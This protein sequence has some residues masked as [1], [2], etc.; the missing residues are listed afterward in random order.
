MNYDWF[1]GIDISKATIDVSFCNSVYPEKYTH[2]K[3]DNTLSGFEKMVVWLKG[4]GVNL[5]KSFIGME[6]TGVYVLHLCT[7]LGQKG[8]I[9][10]LEN[11]LEIKR[12]LGIQ[13]GKNASAS[14]DKV[15]SYRIVD[16]LFSRRHK[17]SPKP[18]SSKTILEIKNLLAYRERSIK[19]KVSLEQN[20]QDMKATSDLTDNSLIITM[21]EQQLKI[22][23][24]QLKEINKKLQEIVARDDNLKKNYEL[25]V[26]VPGIGLI[27]GVSFLVYTQNFTVFTNGRK[28]ASYSGV[29]PFEWP[30]TAA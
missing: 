11:P 13:R 9:Y 20:I 27:T 5:S 18:L 24:M 30:A 12:S 28:F 26:S 1:I 29:A 8:M 6:H 14:D 4:K 3:F 2:K 15:D 10:A 7:Y 16:F 23:K 19:T 21:S 25:V 22:I 17:L